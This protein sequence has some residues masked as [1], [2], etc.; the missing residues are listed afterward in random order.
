[1]LLQSLLLL[2]LEILGHLDSWLLI[3]DARRGKPWLLELLLRT[4]ATAAGSPHRSASSCACG[5]INHGA[6]C[7]T[8]TTA[9]GAGVA[10]LLNVLH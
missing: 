10:E 2:L 7:G 3:A 6:C 4:T 5:N 9:D 8:G 1:V